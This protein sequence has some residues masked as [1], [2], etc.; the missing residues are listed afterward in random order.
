M[1]STLLRLDGLAKHFGGVVAL[2]GVSFEV[3][4]GET[5]GLIGPN[6]SGK[7]TLFNCVT[8]YLHPEPPSHVEWKGRSIVGCR[9]D[10]IARLGIVR[11]FQDARVFKTMSV[12]E[13][14]L[15]AIQQHQEDR[16]WSR[17]LKTRA[18]RDAEANAQRRAATLLDMI[19]LSRFTDAPIGTLSYGQ[20]KLFILIA[21][22]MPMPDIVLL[23]EPVAAVNPVMIDHIKGYVQELN[24]QGM[25]FLLIEH[26]M[27]VVMDICHRVVVLD[28]GLKIAEGSPD[29]VRN[30]NRVIDAYFGV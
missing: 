27:D 12:M 29:V 9:P 13:G 28:H 15:M 19:G 24:R 17:F 20:R 16:V 26:N 30:D 2:E 7:T 6:G 4:S 18:I 3:N 23:D 1:G 21:A 22:L 8:G 5:V 25:T 14:L 11:T 10:E